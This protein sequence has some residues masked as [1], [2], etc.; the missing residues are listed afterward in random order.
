MPTW[1]YWVAGFVVLQLLRR[2]QQISTFNN[3]AASDVSQLAIAY[4]QA[5]NPSGY[6]WA[7]GVDGTNEAKLFELAAQ[8]VG[9][10][11]QIAQTYQTLYFTTL[12]QDLQNELSAEELAKFW[13]IVNGNNAANAPIPTQPNPQQNPLPVGVRKVVATQ[14]Y[15]VRSNEDP[16]KVLYQAK[17]G[18]TIGE[19]DGE[20]TVTL[21]GLPTAFY[22]AKFTVNLPI[23]VFG[24]PIYNSS[25]IIK[26]LIAKG[27]AKIV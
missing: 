7:I 2:G 27:G 5:L 25:T 9:R 15:N 11:A 1:F 23:T 6:G 18:Q 19:Y 16:S 14:P 22:V 21:N 20:R 8:S 4:R 10:F 12:T 26:N 13:A 3:A 24:F 17:V